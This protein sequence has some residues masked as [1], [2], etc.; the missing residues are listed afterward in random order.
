MPLPVS[1]RDAAALDLDD[2]DADARPGD[3]DVGLAVLLMVAEPLATEQDG[4]VGQVLLERLH[5][6]L[7]GGRP[8]H[9]LVRI[10]TRR[11]TTPRSPGRSD[12]AQPRT[13]RKGATGASGRFY[14]A[15]H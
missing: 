12:T 3:D 2:G 5:E 8:E 10:S 7:L 13:P 6:Q 14:L 1:Q 15:C 4:V 11:H 9:G